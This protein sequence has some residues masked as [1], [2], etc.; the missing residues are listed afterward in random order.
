MLHEKIKALIKSAYI[1]W[2]DF[3]SDIQNT[4]LV[5]DKHSSQEMLLSSLVVA[6]HTIEKGLTMPIRHFPFGEKKA[7][8][9]ARDCRE[10]L[11]RGYNTSDA[12]FQ[13]VLSILQEYITINTQAEVGVNNDIK[14]VIN[15]LL[16]E[17]QLTKASTQHYSIKNEDY[18]DNN[19][20]D[21]VKF[22]ASRF[23]C[24]NLSGH[25][26]V[27][28]LQSALILSMNAPSTC[29][30][31]SH[32]IHLIQS[33]KAKRIILSLQSG[34]RGFGDIV[35]QFI[36]VTSDLRDWSGMH[37]RHAPYID[38]GIY[39]MNLLYSLHYYRIG[40]CTLNLYLNPFRTRQL[41][42]MLNISNNEVPVALIAIGIPPQTFDL[43]RSSRRNVDE[44]IQ[45][46]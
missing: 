36:L 42:K 2:C 13:N 35:D 3:Y 21:F 34:N 27:D 29:N 19:D 4:S 39:I 11:N 12:R 30:R 33:D 32:R 6:S 37:Q 43:A 45:K 22:S 10:Y 26:P 15:E 9:I 7:W 31:Q 23:S 20:S 16:S 8:D 44:I 28:L 14:Q 46:H 40:A 17:V 1:Y 24:R 5:I 25:V 38:G 41:H 18:F